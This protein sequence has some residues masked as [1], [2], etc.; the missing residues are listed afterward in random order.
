ME[1][2]KPS[3]PGIDLVE[4][5]FIQKM[6]S[7]H[8]RHFLERYFSEE[9]IA[10]YQK[11]KKITYLAGRFATKEAIFKSVNIPYKP[12]LVTVYNDP[13]GC[14]QIYLGDKEFYIK[15]SISLSHHGEYAIAIA[16]I[17]QEDIGAFKKFID[18]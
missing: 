7:K 15:D 17:R 5:G 13:D 11:T 8:G 18:P 9:E 1:N 10:I 12:T 6:L 4:I 3:R 14:P 16:Q 2:K